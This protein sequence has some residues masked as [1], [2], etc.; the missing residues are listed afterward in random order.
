MHSILDTY[1]QVSMGH[2]ELRWSST[3]INECKT[4]KNCAVGEDDCES[5][6]PKSSWN[7]GSSKKTRQRTEDMESRGPQHL[8]K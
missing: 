4:Q 6:V 7:H 2:R 1:I 8:R 3:W 5:L